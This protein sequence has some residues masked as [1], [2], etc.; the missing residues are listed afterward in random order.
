MASEHSGDTPPTL[1]LQIVPEP[2][3]LVMLFGSVAILFIRRR[4][5]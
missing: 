3:V 1:I 5:R 4:C 2:T